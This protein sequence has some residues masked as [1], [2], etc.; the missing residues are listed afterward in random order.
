MGVIRDISTGL[1]PRVLRK[2]QLGQG[3]PYIEGH[4]AD[5]QRLAAS[6]CP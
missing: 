1:D 4:V 2:A 5:R 3:A 6:L